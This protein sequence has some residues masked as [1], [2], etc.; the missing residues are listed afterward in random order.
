[1]TPG[2][3]RAIRHGI[4]LASA[5]VLVAGWSGAL[6]GQN[7]PFGR[8]L[9]LYQAQLRGWLAGA[10]MYPAYEL[11]G[12][13]QIVEGSILYPPVAI[14]AFLPTLL[15]PAILWWL[16]PAG[17]VAWAFRDVRLRVRAILPVALCLALPGSALLITAGNP[18][19]WIIAALAVSLRWNGAASAFI[20]LKPSVFPLAL[21]GIRKRWWWAVAGAIALVSLALLPHT[22]D[23]IHVL[24]NARNTNLRTGLTYSI[25]DMPLLMAPV[26]AWLGRVRSLEEPAP[27]DPPPPSG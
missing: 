9:T 21:I 26:I 18:D 8:D 19:I 6:L 15:M 1:M 14:V 11:A 5:V 27:L 13:F 4:L 2:R 16:I 24:L 7:L 25:G 3:L 10:P 20:W 23:W 22:I 12:P 17:I